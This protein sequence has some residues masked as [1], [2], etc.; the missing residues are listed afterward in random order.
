MADARFCNHVHWLKKLS[1]QN[2]ECE[3]QLVGTDVR[4]TSSQHAANTAR[5][6]HG[7]S[8][9]TR[10]DQRMLVLSKGL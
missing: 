4:K 8:E 9:Q 7:T 3:E 5:Q 10:S 6:N 2:D 1:S